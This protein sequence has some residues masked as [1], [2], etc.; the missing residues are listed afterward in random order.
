VAK[1]SVT[2]SEDEKLLYVV[3]SNS[4]A[5][6]V[7]YA[8]YTDSGTEA[9]RYTASFSLQGISEPVVYES[10]VVMGDSRV[11]TTKHKAA[12]HSTAHTRVGAGN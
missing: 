5:K 4:V 8:L 1:G 7:F 2:L 10:A 6:A 9:W 3:A 11:C 12:S